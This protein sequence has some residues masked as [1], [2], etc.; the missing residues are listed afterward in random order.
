MDPK[1]RKRVLDFKIPSNR[2]ELQDI[3]GIIIFLS[4]FCP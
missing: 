3:L 4:K 2:R 1:K